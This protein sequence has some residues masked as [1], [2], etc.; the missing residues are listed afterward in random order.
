MSTPRAT[1]LIP[2][3]LAS[4]HM[5]GACATSPR[6]YGSGGPG[7]TWLIVDQQDTDADEVRNRVARQRGWGWRSHF[8]TSTHDQGVTE[9]IVAPFAYAGEDPSTIEINVWLFADP[10]V[11]GRVI[12]EATPQDGSSLQSNWDEPL[13]FPITM[14][15]GWHSQDLVLPQFQGPTQSAHIQWITDAP[16][17]QPDETAGA[18]Q[19]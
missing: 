7:E 13:V 4:L 16:A 5:L 2:A 12:A 19:D 15:K 10:P 18:D 8:I 1:L 6:P 9:F 11:T 14:T 17:P 3:F